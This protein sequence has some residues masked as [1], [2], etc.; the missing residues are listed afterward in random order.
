MFMRPMLKPAA[1]AAAANAAGSRSSRRGSCCWQQLQ[2]LPLLLAVGAAAIHTAAVQL[3]LA[4]H[5]A[6]EACSELVSDCAC[7]CICGCAFVCGCHN[8]VP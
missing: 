1:V 7:E 8:L 3:S 6:C 5:I 4:G 2:Q